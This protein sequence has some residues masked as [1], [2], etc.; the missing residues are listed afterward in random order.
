MIASTATIPAAN[1]SP[2]IPG[3][4]SLIAHTYL[5][6]SV[7]LPAR[8]PAAR[9]TAMSIPSATT[10]DGAVQQR[11]TD[12]AGMVAP[13]RHRGV[14]WG[15]RR[16]AVAN[17]CEVDVVRCT[18]IRIRHHRVRREGRGKASFVNITFH[19][20]RM[21]VE[22]E[23]SAKMGRQF[24]RRIRRRDAQRRWLTDIPQVRLIRLTFGNCQ[25]ATKPVRNLAGFERAIR[26]KR[27][28][29]HRVAHGIVDEPRSFVEAVVER[30]VNQR[31]RSRARS[32][33]SDGHIYVAIRILATSG[34]AVNGTATSRSIS[35]ATFSSSKY[36]RVACGERLEGGRSWQFAEWRKC[37]LRRLVVLQRQCRLLHVVLAL[38]SPRLARGLNRRQ[39][40]RPECR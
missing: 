28:V 22:V 11:D 35:L 17:R 18:R 8:V 7:S 29:T 32:F 9:Q 25:R 2:P 24:V 13:C 33:S 30:I 39:Q 6:E 38:C 19:P 1:C 3:P 10:P 27:A 20:F 16:L 26:R 12:V 40:K 31:W 37:L 14:G 23:R 34:C 21:A 4:A 5:H 15:S 36:G